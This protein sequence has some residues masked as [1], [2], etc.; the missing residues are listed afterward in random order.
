MFPQLLTHLSFLSLLFRFNTL[1]LLFLQLLGRFEDILN[2][3]GSLFGRWGSCLFVYD[4]VVVGV[5]RWGD[6]FMFGQILHRWL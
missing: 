6:I 4:L 3:I 2:R 5:C 1:G